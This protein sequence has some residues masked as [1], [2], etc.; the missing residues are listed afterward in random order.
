MESLVS[1]VNILFTII[2]IEI[3]S[4][5]VFILGAFIINFIKSYVKSSKK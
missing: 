2:V 5:A 3:L 4:I 1:I